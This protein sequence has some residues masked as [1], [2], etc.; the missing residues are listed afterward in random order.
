MQTFKKLFYF[1][2]PHERKQGILL[3]M[4]ITFVALL[5]MIGVASIM[6]FVAVLSNPDIVETNLIL[7][8]MYQALKNFGVEN[9][10]SFIFVLG[11]LV[12]SLLF[13]SLSCKGL[14]TYAQIRFAQMCQYN[15]S[16]R[17]VEEYLNKPYSWSLNKNSSEISKNIL[18][19][20]G[21]VVGNG[22]FETL[23]LIAK[24]SIMILIIF[25]L[26][27]VDPKLALLVG[28]VLCFSYGLIYYFL[29][30]Y[31]IRIAK[32]RFINNEL[33]FKVVSE[34]FNATRDI[35][36][37]GLEKIFTQ[38]FSNHAKIYAKTVSN[39]EIIK[40]LPRFLLEAI[41]FGGIM[42]IM[43]YLIGKT[44]SFDNSLP[45]LS[46][47]VF[48]G[49][50]LM[51]ALQQCY[52]SVTQLSF[53]GPSIDKLYN[54]IQNFEPYNLNQDESILSLNKSINLN[55]IYYNYPNTA[56]TTLKDINISISAKTTVGL[57]GATGSGKTTTVDIILGLLE[58]Q[59]GTLE[60]DG[61]IITK[62]NLR[63]WQRNIGYVPQNIF[64]S[65]D[66]I[67]SNIAFGVKPEDINQEAIE[68]ASKIANL[69]EFVINELPKEYKTIIGER[70]VR[71]SGG[72]RQ[73]IAIA[74]ALYHNPHVLI[75]DEAT[76]ALDNQTEQAVMEAINNLSKDI[77]IILIAHRLSTVKNCDNI[78]FLS[79][80]ELKSQGNF[81]EL[82]KNNLSFF[83]N[84]EKQ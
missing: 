59:R 7:N 36:L 27:L 60:V 53:A 2:K 30:K 17:L 71:L 57:I 50:R 61:E 65:D 1:L 69:H 24:S 45:V 52:A 8:T 20:V 23:Q 82:K 18:D 55:N 76:S 29:R 19:E 67:A 44:G 32:E 31:L 33:R 34:A 6:P 47:Y 22:I 15:I 75:L 64:L 28:F 16:K 66:T 38:Y 46:L 40:Q 42:L 73:R 39:A 77:T 9:I 56:S 68:K 62:K 58:P 54:E 5:D 26:I 35:K 43:L 37:R 51:P 84:S 72:Q 74:R 70:G 49:Y 48:A 83:E 14:A 41:I 11:L 10:Q 12:L 25:L 3:F 81:E 80:G 78:F 21:M 13:I 4:M 79:K 63:A